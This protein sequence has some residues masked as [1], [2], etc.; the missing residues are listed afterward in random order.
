L[1]ELP[2]SRAAFSLGSNIVE[3]AVGVSFAANTVLPLKK[4]WDMCVR[5]RLTM[6]D[7]VPVFA[8]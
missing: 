8:F 5:S 4:A 1:V 2:S 6:V 3:A 7:S